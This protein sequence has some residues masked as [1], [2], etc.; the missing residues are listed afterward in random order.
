MK[1]ELQ[2]GE[3]RPATTKPHTWRCDHVA[4]DGRACGHMVVAAS[5]EALMQGRLSH[6][7]WASAKVRLRQGGVDVDA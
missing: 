5:P 1:R 2:P 6:S 3:C 7:A 4:V